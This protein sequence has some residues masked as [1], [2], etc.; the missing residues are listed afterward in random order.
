M[1]EP[2]VSPINYTIPTQQG[3]NTDDLLLIQ[4]TQVSTEFN[5][6]TDY[7]EVFVYDLNNQIVG[8][9]YGFI[10]YQTYQDSS[11]NLGPQFVLNSIKIDPVADLSLY[12]FDIGEY[13]INY[14]F[15][16]SF[17]SSSVDTPFYIS[18]ISSDRTELRLDSNYLNN[19]QLSLLSGEFTASRFE[20]QLDD[21]YLNFGDNNIVIANNF[22]L[23]NTT[24]DYSVLVKLYEPLPTEF[25]IKSQTW[26]VDKISDPA[27]FQVEF[28][29]EP[30]LLDDAI[31]LK[32]PNTNL[33]LKDEIN[34]STSLQ[35]YNSI[36]SS[37]LSSSQ[38]QYFSLLEEKGIDINIDFSDYSNFI[39][40]SSAETRLSNFYYKVQQI[41]NYSNELTILDSLTYNIQVSSS[42]AILQSNINFII[43]N[44]DE[45]EYYLYYNSSSYAWPKS[46][47]LK[48]YTLYSTG[49]T[50]VLNWYGS[51]NPTDAYYGGQIL[52]ASLYDG[53]NQNYIYYSIPEYIRNNS[54]NAQY[55]LFMDMIGQLFDN[56][57]I[58]Y[59]DVTN[60]YN[61]DNRLDYGVSKDL[62]AEA[63][64]DL[65]VNIYQNNFSSADVFSAFLGINP[66]GGLLP[67]TG[68]EVITTYVT[69]SNNGMIPLDDIEKSI[70]KRIYH[71]LP[72]LLKTKGTVTGLQTLISLYG[73]DDTILR[74]AEFGGKDKNNVNDWDYWR[75]FYNYKLDTSASSQTI[76]SEWVLNS[77]WNSP[78]N[79]PNTLQFRFKAPESGPVESAVAIPSQSLW[80]LG[81]GSEVAIVLEYTGSGLTTG[82]YSGSV[83]DP[84]YQ[85][86]TLKFTADGMNTSASVYLP[87][88]NGDWWSVMVTRTGSNDFTLYAG[89]NIYNGDDGAQIGFLATSSYTDGGGGGH[90]IVAISS[91]FGGETD[92]ITL[93][94]NNV[95]YNMFSGS[96]QEVRYYTSTLDLYTFEDWTMNPSSIEGLGINSAPSQ[97]AFRAPLGG[98]LYTGPISV[99]PQVTGSWVAT[100][101]FANDSNFY[102]GSNNF[103]NNTET[104]YMDQPAAGIKNI[105]SN[106]IQIVNSVL[107]SG[108]T[109]SALRSIQQTVPASSSYTP[110]ITYTEVA[111][112]PQN[113]IND[114]IMD[115]LGYF[116]MGDYIGDPRQRFNQ[117]TSY[118][119]LDKLRDEYFIKY[120][121]NYDFT[122]YIRLIKYF[123]NSLFKMIQDFTPARTSLASGV[124]IKQNLLERNKYPQPEVTSSIYDYSGSIDTAFI[125]GG[126]GGSVNKLNGLNTNPYYLDNGLS[127]V[128]GL[129]QSWS[130][131]IINPYGV[132][133]VLHSSQD[134][135]YNGEYSGSN[136]VVEDGELNTECN[137]YKQVDTTIISYDIVHY[138]NN[139]SG[140][141]D[142]GSGADQV[143]LT[144]FLG[145]TPVSG[146]LNLWWNS[147]RVTDRET[148]PNTYYDTYTVEYVTIR[149]VSDNG[150]DLTGYI[151]NATKLL[152][153][154]ISLNPALSATTGW[155]AGAY[156]SLTNNSE[157]FLELD[158]LSISE[159]ANYYVLTVVQSN[160][161]E[162]TITSQGT[163]FLDQSAPFPVNIS[164]DLNTQILLEPYVPAGF[165]NSACNPLIN[166]SELNRFSKW[167]QQVDYNTNQLT[168]VNFE[169]ILSG[170]AYP[171]DV[172]DS[173][174]TSYQF[175]GIRYWGSKNTT[176]NFNTASTSASL[177][178]QNYQN[179]NIGATTLGYA[180]VNNFDTGIYEFA[181]GGGTYP[182]IAGGGAVKL[183]QIL[184]IDNT[185]SAGVISP[186]TTFFGDIVQANVIP[187]S[188]PQF[189]QYTTT[190]NI[191][192][193]ARVITAE[194]GVPT[195]S[196]YM[197]P[198]GSTFEAII[199]ANDST[200]SFTN[201]ASIVTTNSSGNYISGSAISRTDMIQT[202]SASLSEGDR[203]FMSYYYNM[204]S[205]V[206]GTLLPVNV[207]YSSSLPDGSYTH[208]LTRNGVYEITSSGVVSSNSFE[209]TPPPRQGKT[210]G[211]NAGILIW[212]AI[213]DNTFVLF[214][215]ATLSG[216][217]KGNIIMPNASP[218]IKNNLTF[219]TEN[220]GTNPKNQ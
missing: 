78:D 115:S 105:I 61:A 51:T 44:F 22:L 77:D 3:Y 48:P 138:T 99:H 25:D 137:P 124:V 32:G 104:V 147:N 73:V 38:Q 74:V 126:A 68:S 121:S 220:Y 158:I 24:E 41:E 215:G 9:D 192:N 112:S 23:D 58:Y 175:S 53:D 79:V 161:Y 63:I 16:R 103:T 40:F 144:T 149:K 110:N 171:A 109:L 166:N 98:E 142:G 43:E 141:N 197:I 30:V 204:V 66:D 169:A 50:E 72:Y 14:N 8:S 15:Y 151:P 62:I 18:E 181:W 163:G 35:N 184:N 183:S 182:E 116:N 199:T 54:D 17:F 88:F 191:P 85:Y 201:S 92:S 81:D 2:I 178:V 13:I 83:V 76:A 96:Y 101:S 7:I 196:S 200:V 107:P 210:V 37:S 75:D 39:H 216:V 133:V 185:G 11:N 162:F 209:V 208:P 202:I 218:T 87:F 1:S 207:G 57:W 93:T 119:A 157:D 90:W 129:T 114:D 5:P 113:E 188:Q 64:R 122:D 118:P 160:G 145:V 67:L 117:D 52:T 165:Y 203:W 180:S 55:I 172:P 42:K 152:I 206:A 82:S 189:T 31:Y 170:S 198:S 71:N 89:S 167:W 130:E 154:A 205:P 195:I 143:P 34:A 97:L 193:T 4:S 159:Q 212:K 155:A 177:D 134:E 123:D 69:S 194:F 60:K 26:I 94:G 70:Y 125:S 100:S 19:D 84:Y 214:N 21:F 150:I 211:D 176:D 111:F 156:I 33:N 102:L 139:S 106:K 56:I 132:D 127:N 128:Y 36:I 140:G 120:K 47:S 190:A 49:S 146:R 173:N 164:S 217:G 136:L 80:S 27:S 28:P 213:T 131:S 135:F 65:G 153:P 148:S 179:S 6:T 219:I 186:L 20:R 174:Y 168:P 95:T 29:F 46:N 108:D 91:S 59:K 12:L 45:Y 187:N 86:A 10:N